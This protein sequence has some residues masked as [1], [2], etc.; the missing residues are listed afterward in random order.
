MRTKAFTLIELL[1][2]VAIIAILAAIAVPNFLAAQTRAKVSR[3]KAD[4]R[5]IAVGI[6]TFRIDRNRYPPDIQDGASM[7]VT[8]LKVLTTPISYLTALPE[9]PFAHK[10]KILEYTASKPTNPYALPSDRTAFVY[11]LTYDYA[12]RYD[13]TSGTFEAE[14]TWERITRTPGSVMWGMRSAGPDL[15]PAW[16]GE[17]E[18]PYDPSNGTVS[19]GNIFWT[20]P[21]NG[22][23]QP[24][25]LA[26]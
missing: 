17:N 22:E 16:L 19:R 20:G 13:S 9:D 23:D 8:R 14:A 10:G 21:G 25:N 2:V 24:R 11:P 26:P 6:E 18:P 1:V 5:T 7:Y 4:M 3:A 15:Y 12:S